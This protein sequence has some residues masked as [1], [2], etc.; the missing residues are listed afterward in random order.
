MDLAEVGD[1]KLRVDVA[2]RVQ[3]RVQRRVIE[4]LR[5]AVR[6]PGGRRRGQFLRV[7]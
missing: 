6:Q 4:S 2:L 1:G 7:V 3:P 5:F